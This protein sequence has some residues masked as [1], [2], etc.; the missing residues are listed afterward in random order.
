MTAATNI[1]HWRNEIDRVDDDLLRLFNERA[2]YAIEIGLEKR[3][4][5]LPIEVPEREAA[6][7][8]RMT[9]DNHGPLDS[10]AVERLFDAVIAESRIAEGAMLGLNPAAGTAS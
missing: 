6:I 2:H 10:E 8:K 7:M 9:S 1:N 4:L 5:G 3:R